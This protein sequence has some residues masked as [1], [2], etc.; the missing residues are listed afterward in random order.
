MKGFNR[1]CGLFNHDASRCDDF[2]V[3]ERAEILREMSLS[4]QDLTLE[5]DSFDNEK[6]DRDQSLVKISR[7]TYGSRNNINCNMMATDESVMI[8]DPTSLL[9]PPACA[10]LDIEDVGITKQQVNVV[11]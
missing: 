10:D 4:L 3:K 11:V 9:M 6:L 7:N 2:L 1:R 8:G 5:E